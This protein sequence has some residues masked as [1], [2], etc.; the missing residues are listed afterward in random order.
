[1]GGVDCSTTLP[2]RGLVIDEG[3]QP[4]VVSNEDSSM[5]DYERMDD[6]LGEK[7]SIERLQ[8][9]IMKIALCSVESSHAST[10]LPTMVSSSCYSDCCSST[11]TTKCIECSRKDR[12]IH[13]Q[14]NDIQSLRQQLKHVA[15]TMQTSSPPE[16]LYCDDK[17]SLDSDITTLL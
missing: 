14:Q 15:A 2:V 16:E 5:L 4:Q 12:I 3:G 9:K 7:K 13:R 10:T 17:V 8:E 11:T 6:R 1:M